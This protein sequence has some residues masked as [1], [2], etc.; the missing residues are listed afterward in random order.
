MVGKRVQCS[1]GNCIVKIQGIIGVPEIWLLWLKCHKTNNENTKVLGQSKHCLLFFNF[2]TLSK[3]LE[4][5]IGIVWGTE[6]GVHEEETSRRCHYRAQV[7]FVGL[8]RLGWGVCPDQTILK[9][10]LWPDSYL[11]ALLHFLWEEFRVRGGKHT[12][13]PG[14][15]EVV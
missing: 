1:H 13:L 4:K 11:E 8:C 2:T 15:T 14:V 3:Q 7:P 6:S 12:T 10:K 5:R 9:W